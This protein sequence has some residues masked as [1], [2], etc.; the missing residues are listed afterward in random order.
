MLAAMSVLLGVVG[1]PLAAAFA[2]GLPLTAAFAVAAAR[3]PL[4]LVALYAVLIPF[5]S[6]INVP[7]GLPAGLDNASSL[8]GLLVI[9]GLS[10][11]LVFARHRAATFPA[12]LPFW[13]LLLGVSLLT[14]LWSVD[15]ERTFRD[16]IALTSV[17]VLYVVCSLVAVNRRELSLVEAGIAAGGAITGLVAAY[18]LATS[19]IAVSGGDIP[20]FRMDVGGQG[21]DPN[22][23]AAILVLP[24]VVATARATRDGGMLRRALYLLAAAL[25]GLAI[26]L[27]ASRGSVIAAL[28]AIAVLAAHES[29]GKVIAL[30]LAVPATIAAAALAVAPETAISR[31]GKRETTGRSDIWRLGIAACPQYCW[32]GSG[33]GAFGEVHKRQVL[34][35]A[36]GKGHRLRYQAHNMLLAMAIEAGLVAL[37]LAVIGLAV[38]ASEL[39]KLPATLRGPPLAAFAGLLVSNMFVANFDYKYFWLVL[40]YAAF[41]VEEARQGGRSRLLGSPA[42]SGSPGARHAPRDQPSPVAGGHPLGVSFGHTRFQHLSKLAPL[43]RSSHREGRIEHHN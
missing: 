24:L 11:H 3:R 2:V 8:A 6:G 10:V 16:L 21:G 19:T 18:Q 29:R 7:L 43:P 39:L 41:A 28:A 40:I 26:I 5:G 32:T 22:I 25:T 42:Q 9:A 38:T 31:F 35:S 37:A 34:A 1:L 14:Y 27:T 20:R 12:A 30:Y 15:P 13:L 17:I 36:V 4:I 23:T 33:W